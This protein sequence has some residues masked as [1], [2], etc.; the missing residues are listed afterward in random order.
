MEIVTNKE[1]Q[2][3]RHVGRGVGLDWMAGACGRGVGLRGGFAGVGYLGGAV[4][5][6]GGWGVAASRKR[7]SKKGHM[8]N[9]GYVLG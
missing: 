7:K 3:F 6:W 5:R 4:E 9:S 2:L 1:V 8:G